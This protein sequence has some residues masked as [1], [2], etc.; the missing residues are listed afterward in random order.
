MC[1]KIEIN[2]KEKLGRST[3]I[4]TDQGDIIFK[5][6]SAIIDK[7]GF[8]ILNFIGIDL[9]TSS[10][11]NA[12]IGQLYGKYTSE[13]LQKV[14]TVENLDADDKALF[15]EVITRAKAYFAAPEKFEENVSREL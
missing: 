3:A 5:F 13:E 15:V 12:A 9:L 7:K 6:I 4:S 1:K 11:L 2:I 10:F 14:L 8:I